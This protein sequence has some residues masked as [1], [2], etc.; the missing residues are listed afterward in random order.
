MDER[1]RGCGRRRVAREIEV[2]RRPIAC[3]H[4]CMQW[5]AHFTGVLRCGSVWQCPV[6]AMQI[7][8]ERGH[9][10]E[11]AVVA[12]GPARVAMLT[13]T[14]RH[15][16]GHDLCKV[17][18]GVANAYRRLT[19]GA[20]WK[21][22]CQRFGLRHSIRALEVTHGEHHGW[23]PHLHVLWFVERPL[24]EAKYAEAKVWLSQRWRECVEHELGEEHAPTDANGV[25]LRL[26][27]RA[28]YISKFAFELVDGGG[29]RG[30]R[31]NRSPIEIAAD[32]TACRQSKDARI[33]TEYCRSM[34]GA[35]MLTWSRGLRRATGL[36]RE[37]TD[38]DV[39]KGEALPETETVATLEPRAWAALVALGVAAALAVLEAAESEVTPGLA[40][41]AI[42]AVVA[43]GGS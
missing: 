13:L 7:R 29:K 37:K 41:A 26:C 42:Q 8:A 5:R 39:V 16:L 22:L 21:R 32:Y 25:D 33:W 18:R 10:V 38:H 3:S 14:V 2:L 27:R 9:E 30:R 43:A 17:R 15:G 36:A 11:Q 1:V 40:H 6:C 28:D 19:R 24:S 34:R 20:P 12:W 31:E 4:G 23:H 35:K